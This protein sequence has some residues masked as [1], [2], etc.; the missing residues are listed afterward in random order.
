MSLMCALCLALV[1][2]GAR[3]CGA[4]QLYL[5]WEQLRAAVTGRVVSLALPTGATPKGRV[6]DVTP[7]R[8]YLDVRG[9]GPMSINRP[10][11]SVLRIE[12]PGIRGRIVGTIL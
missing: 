7:E 9:R 1:C 6:L 3:P 5:D 12:R 10:F 4:E 11:V 2:F 8:L